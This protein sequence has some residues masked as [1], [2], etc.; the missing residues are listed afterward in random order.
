MLVG[1]AITDSTNLILGEADSDTIRT[2]VGAEMSVAVLILSFVKHSSGPFQTPQRSRITAGKR[3][4]EHTLYRGYLEIVR[5][6]SARG[7]QTKLYCCTS[8]QLASN[9]NGLWH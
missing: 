4:A 7:P 9:T 3:D 8:L 1:S 2:G 6:G 5:R